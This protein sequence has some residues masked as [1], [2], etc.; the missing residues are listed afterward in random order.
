MT[1]PIPTTTI[2]PVS[3]TSKSTL[4]TS[5]PI[6]TTPSPT[7]ITEGL[8]VVGGCSNNYCTAGTNHTELID[9]FDETR[10]QERH[11]FPSVDGRYG[12]IG[13]YLGGGNALFCGGKDIKEEKIK[14][15]C[16]R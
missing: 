3:T 10:R 15:D 16:Y 1:T 7:C 14:D 8:L 6:I 11:P 13:V 5:P 9:P 4:L 12:M 2:Q